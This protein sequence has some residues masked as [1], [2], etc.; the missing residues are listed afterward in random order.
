MSDSFTSRVATLSGSGGLLQGGVTVFDDDDNDHISGDAGR[1][2]IFGDTY[3]WDGAVDQISLQA[4][5][6]ILVAVN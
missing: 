3:K 2:L 1:D 4:A 6:D 5:Q